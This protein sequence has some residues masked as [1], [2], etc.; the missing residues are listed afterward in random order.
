[1]QAIND[2]APSVVSSTT[3]E[4]AANLSQQVFSNPREFLKTIQDNFKEMAQGGNQIT[5][6]DLKTDIEQ[7]S[8]A[9]IRAAAAIA[10]QHFADLHNF[11]PREN[12]IDGIGKKDIDFAADMNDH[13]ILG[14]AIDNGLTDVTAAVGGLVSGALSLG[15]SADAIATGEAFSMLPAVAIG[16]GA[17]LLGLGGY[18][19]YEGVNAYGDLKKASDADAAKF[20]SWLS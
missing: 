18:A 12:K 7:G 19:A 8:T 11:A 14:H 16:V 5:Q 13:K 10:N 3:S 1:M 20:K 17:G 2:K 15:I 4:H 9:Q 6:A